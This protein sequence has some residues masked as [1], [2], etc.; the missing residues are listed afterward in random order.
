MLV[1]E[2]PQQLK[3][4]PKKAGLLMKKTAPT[5]EGLGEWQDALSLGTR[6]R[7]ARW[8][9]SVCRHEAE[10]LGELGAS[11]LLDRAPPGGTILEGGE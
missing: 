2:N 7:E 11:G 1:V 10:H 4:Y 9:D 6:P 8:G 3:L 5:R